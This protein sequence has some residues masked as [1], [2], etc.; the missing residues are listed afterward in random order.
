MIRVGYVLSHAFSG[1]TLI[2]LMLGAHPDITAAGEFH[3]GSVELLHQPR[4]ADEYVCSCGENVL[5]CP[6]WNHVSDVLKQAGV[7]SRF[8]DLGTRYILSDSLLLFNLMNR[9]LRSGC[10]E[11]LRLLLLGK[12]GPVNRKLKQIGQNNRLAIESIL[13]MTGT[14]VF[15]DA[16]KN[17]ARCEHL[18]KAGGLEVRPILLTR[19]G[20]SVALSVKKRNKGDMR[21]AAATWRR[22]Y[23]SA[24]RMLTR[25]RT[26]FMHVR[27]EDLCREPDRTLSEI[28]TFLGTPVHPWPPRGPMPE[29]HVLGNDMRMKFDGTIHAPAPWEGKIT[30]A[31]EKIFNRMCGA[32]SRRL[33][34]HVG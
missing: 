30:A 29:F 15:I 5:V 7:E 33:G 17:P 10:L 18:S 32:L 26:P 27:Y 21:S 23:A 20:R 14:N 8:P 28:H 34:Y 31:E 6:F 25:L 4:A 9:S 19:D 12:I 1:S 3:G 22:F 2:S 24:F 11:K 16:S 13:N